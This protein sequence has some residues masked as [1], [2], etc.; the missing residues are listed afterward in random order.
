MLRP[1]RVLLAL[2]AAAGGACASAS[3]AAPSQSVRSS[4]A[5]VSATELARSNAD[6]LYDAIAKLR[7]EW[8]TS[9]GP[10]SMT[11]SSP[12]T[13]NVFLNGSIAGDADLLQVVGVTDVAEVRYW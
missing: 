9:R 5:Q 6:N 4:R 13:V 8:L 1:L 7:P 11:N 3:S 2:A 10:T 12:T